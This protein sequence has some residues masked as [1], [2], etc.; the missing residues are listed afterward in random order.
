MQL[1]TI[2]NR[3]QKHRSFVYGQ[4]EWGESK[5]AGEP[6][7]EV[8]VRARTNSRPL[9]SGCHWSGPGYDTL[10]PRRF[11]FVPLWGLAVLFVYTMRRVDC[12]RCGVKVEAVPWAVGKQQITTTYAWF[13]AGWAKRMSWLE[14]A[15]ALQTTWDT[16]FRAVEMAVEWGRV[17]MDRT[18]IA[19][20][21][22]DEILW[23]RGH[24]YLTVVYQIDES[25]K[26]LLWVGQDRKAKTL[27]RFFHGLGEERTTVLE[28]ICSDMWKPYLTVIKK[29]A[30]QAIHVLD[31]FHIM[32]HMNKAIR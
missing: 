15:R 11:E 3:I 2:L 1:K 12:P 17:H 20:I 6:V 8:E 22:V 27:L 18:G 30:A 29:K 14:V 21:G 9:C 24:K 32:A 19:A 13:L 25:C 10:A 31:R 7:I 23:Q 16:V 28:F 5:R 26:R 4:M